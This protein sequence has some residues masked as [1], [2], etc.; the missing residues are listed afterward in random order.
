M[1][2]S[3]ISITLPLKVSV[4]NRVNRHIGLLI[5]LDT[6][7][8]GFIYVNFRRDNRHVRDRHDGGRS[9]VLDTGNHC[10]PY[11]H[12]KVGHNSIQRCDRIELT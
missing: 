5:H 6:H 9:G 1:A 4:R 11:P 3:P 12:W 2:V 8:V 7:D 10:F